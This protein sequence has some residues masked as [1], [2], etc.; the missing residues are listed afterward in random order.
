MLRAWRPIEAGLNVIPIATAVAVYFLVEAQGI[1][2]QKVVSARPRGTWVF[3]RAVTC[4]K[5][6]VNVVYFVV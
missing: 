6:E 4:I 1:F 2:T 5:E 3:A